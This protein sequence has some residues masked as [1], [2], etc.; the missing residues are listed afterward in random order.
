[1]KGQHVRYCKHIMEDGHRCNVTF[2]VKGYKSLREYCKEHQEYLNHKSGRK[3]RRKNDASMIEKSEFL[4][5]IMPL[6]DGYEKKLKKLEAENKQLKKEIGNI[7]NMIEGDTLE[8]FIKNTSHGIGTWK[9]SKEK[10][11]QEYANRI[12]KLEK[13]I[14]DLQINVDS[15]DAKKIENLLL[16]MHSRIRKLEGEEE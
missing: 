13:R 8:T 4:D 6:W 1:M 15:E 14:N 5:K 7:F 2:R 3:N 11:Y 16:S 9:L 12:G 10:M